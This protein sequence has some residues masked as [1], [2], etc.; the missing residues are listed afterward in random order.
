M[1]KDTPNASPGQSAPGK[2]K[3]AKLREI[4]AKVRQV[5]TTLPHEVSI[6]GRLIKEAHDAGAWP[7]GSVTGDRLRRA[8]TSRGSDNPFTY[9]GETAPNWVFQAYE[10]VLGDLISGLAL[11]RGGG[12]E[13]VKWEG[14]ILADGIE[15]EADRIDRGG[16][17]E[18]SDI[19]T[20]N[21]KTGLLRIGGNAYT[22]T[23]SERHVLRVLVQ[24]QSATLTELQQ[25]A[26]R[27]DKVL[28]GLLKKYPAPQKAYH[29]PR[30]C[31]SWWIF[32]DDRAC[33]N[34]AITWPFFDWCFC[35]Q[36]GHGKRQSDSRIPRRGRNPPANRG[37]QQRTAGPV[38][39]PS[40]SYS[41]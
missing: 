38:G 35:P 29:A 1:A 41:S 39:S 13:V 30:S 37:P 24:Q 9:A 23:S 3:A 11:P 7:E 25:A 2:A 34:F 18:K 32:N 5:S 17:P 27:P 10:A 15:R 26:N 4:A 33:Q 19:P 20:F 40:G 36:Y 6:F 8:L 12:E 22:P 16:K 28:K 31:W 14:E 21:M